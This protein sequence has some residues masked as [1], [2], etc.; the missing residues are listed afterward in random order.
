MPAK[1]RDHSEPVSFLRSTFGETWPRP[2][3]GSRKYHPPRFF[4]APLTMDVKLNTFGPRAPLRLSSSDGTARPTDRPMIAHPSQLYA[5][6]IESRLAG[7]A[8][9]T[10]F[11]SVS[12]R[13]F[14]FLEC[15]ELTTCSG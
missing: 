2:P 1:G 12:R 13:Y 6:A 7:A 15:M 11:V 14:I 10:L 3:P 4:C 9:S 8:A 5:V